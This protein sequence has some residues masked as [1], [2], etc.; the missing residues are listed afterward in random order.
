MVT[1]A[2]TV[3]RSMI[4]GESSDQVYPQYALVYRAV[5][6]LQL[7][8]CTSMTTIPRPLDEEDVSN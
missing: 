7:P 6:S 1:E 5:N 8:R 2:V 4:N 3:T